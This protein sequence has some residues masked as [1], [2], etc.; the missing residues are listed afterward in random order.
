MV[1]TQVCSF[2]ENASNYNFDLCSLPDVFYN[3]KKYLQISFKKKNPKHK[4]YKAI[5][6]K[7]SKTAKRAKVDNKRKHQEH[8]AVGF[9]SGH[10]LRVVRLS[11]LSGSMLSGEPAL[12][13]S[14]PLPTSKIN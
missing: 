7:E 5:L 10:D 11:A 13:V 14:L 8:L 6:E 9:S 3:L 12:R 2:C 4:R 1:V